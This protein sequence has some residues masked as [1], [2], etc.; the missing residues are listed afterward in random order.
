MV[1][2]RYALGIAWLTLI[3]AKTIAS[4]TGIGHLAMDARE[5]MQ[6]D[7]VILTVLLYALLGK[8]SDSTTKMLEQRFLKWNPAYRR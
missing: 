5:F 3:V 7:V 2:F 6:T 1:G 4:T 8:M